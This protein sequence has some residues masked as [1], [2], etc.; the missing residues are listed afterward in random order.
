MKEGRG[1]GG[2]R[3]PSPR[4]VRNLPPPPPPLPPPAFVT[5]DQGGV[6]EGKKKTKQVTGEM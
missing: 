4:S 6:E 1:E 3:R 2:A 5:G